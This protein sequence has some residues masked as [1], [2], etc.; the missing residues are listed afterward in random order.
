MVGNDAFLATAAVLVG[1]AAL[2]FASKQYFD[3]RATLDSLETSTSS[4]DDVSGRLEAVQQSISTR[5][6]GNFPEFIEEIVDVLKGA[7]KEVWILCDIPGYGMISSP[8]FFPRYLEQIQIKSLRMPVHMVTS[9][10]PLADN[11][12]R[13][14]NQSGWEAYSRRYEEGIRAM[15]EQY[16][17]DAEPVDELTCDRYVE[18]LNEAQEKIVRRMDPETRN[19]HVTDTNSIVPL[20]FWVADGVDAVFALTSY[21]KQAREVGFRTSDRGLIQA[22]IG[23]CNRYRDEA[24]LPPGTT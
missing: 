19:V 23:I 15:M 22:L 24:A 7:R 8:A 6:V 3:A 14:I 17:D 20:L 18:C 2:A 12:R 10:G 16:H 5:M 9:R 13:R 11:A 1:I 4:L 21:T